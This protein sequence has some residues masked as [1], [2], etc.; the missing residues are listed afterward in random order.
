MCVCVCACVR[1]RVC[2]CVCVCVYVCVCVFVYIYIYMCVCVCICV[3]AC[4]RACVQLYRPKKDSRHVECRYQGSKCFHYIMCDAVQLTFPCLA[5]SD[6]SIFGLVRNR[7]VL[8]NTS[9]VQWATTIRRCH[10]R[11]CQTRSKK[12]CF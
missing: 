5:E 2:V 6:L 8:A 9:L 10:S 7:Q 12:Q 11:P 3:C 1:V 4:V